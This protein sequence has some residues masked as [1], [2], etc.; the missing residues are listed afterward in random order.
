MKFVSLITIALVAL[1]TDAKKTADPKECEG[2]CAH[3]ALPAV[4]VPLN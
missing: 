2:A 3:M 4:D 1:S